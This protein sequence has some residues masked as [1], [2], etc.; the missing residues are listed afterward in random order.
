[1]SLALHWCQEGSLLPL[2]SN[3]VTSLVIEK[4][5]N[6]QGTDGPEIFTFSLATLLP[7]ISYKQKI[8]KSI[9]EGD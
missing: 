9:G 6:N 3:H 4:Y 8:E 2:A 1:M 7:E 5:F